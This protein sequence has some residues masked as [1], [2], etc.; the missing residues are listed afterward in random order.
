MTKN[1]FLE[2]ALW[3]ELRGDCRPQADKA[4]DHRS[5]PK[6]PWDVCQKGRLSNR[7]GDEEGPRTVASQHRLTGDLAQH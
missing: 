4:H 3:E 1:D 7:M 2:R 5:K 6:V